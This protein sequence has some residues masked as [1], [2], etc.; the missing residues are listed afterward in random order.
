M[1]AADLAELQALLGQMRE[2]NLA[3]GKATPTQRVSRRAAEPAKGTQGTRSL[4]PCSAG[5][6]KT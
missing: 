3:A 2:Q 4:T 6:T 5:V 1:D